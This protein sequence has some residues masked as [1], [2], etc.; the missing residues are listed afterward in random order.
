MF[1]SYLVNLSRGFNVAQLCDPKMAKF[2]FW[3]MSDHK[4][5]NSTWLTLVICFDPK[6][7]VVEK[8]VLKSILSSRPNTQYGV[9]AKRQKIV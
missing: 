5:L 1:F 9:H 2:L 8:N 4:E 7:F 3:P 6:Y